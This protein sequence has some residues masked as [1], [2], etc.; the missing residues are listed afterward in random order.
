MRCVVLLN[1][2][3]W[4][5]C[6]LVQLILLTGSWSGL[7]LLPEI[8]GSLSALTP[9]WAGS[10]LEAMHLAFTI[11]SW[12][13]NHCI[14]QNNEEAAA[15]LKLKLQGSDSFHFWHKEVQIALPEFATHLPNPNYSA[16]Q[17]LCAVKSPAHCHS[18]QPST[19]LLLA[20]PVCRV[21][22][23]IWLCVAAT[24]LTSSAVL[25]HCH[26][27]SLA[28]CNGTLRIFSWTATWQSRAPILSAGHKQHIVYLFFSS[29]IA[30]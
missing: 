23:E 17:M 6:F 10:M 25:A 11:L 13:W 8:C 24:L 18:T 4:F 12:V 3:S 28:C 27:E 5:V 26:P 9:A 2:K 1:V 14:S 7:Q 20:A 15:K 21:L 22:S 19:N 16:P 30:I 29:E